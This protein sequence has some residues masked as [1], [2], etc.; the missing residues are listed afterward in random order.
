MKILHVI[1]GISHEGGG[2]S[3]SCQGLVSSLAAIGEDVALLT[4]RHGR[5]PWVPGISRFYNGESFESVLAVERP[6]VVH[7]H[8]IWQPEI[9]NC[10]KICRKLQLP[11]VISPRGMLEPWSLQ[12]K[13]LKKR[14][15]RLLYQDRDLRCA[16]ALHATSDSE[17][18]QFRKLGFCN[19]IIIS[20]NGVNIPKVLPPRSCDKKRRA[21]FVSR[22]HPKKGVA[23]LITAWAHVKPKNWCCEFVYTASGADEI[24]YEKKVREMACGLGI[25]EDFIFTGELD[26]AEKWRAYMRSD[27]FVLPTYSENFGIVIAE[28]LYAGLPVITTKGAPWRDLELERCGWWI[29]LPYNQKANCWKELDEALCQATLGDWRR[30]MGE[31]A[32]MGQRGHE[33]IERKYLWASAG[34]LMRDGYRRV[35]YNERSIN[36]HNL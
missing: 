28:A 4:I 18:N 35:I 8:C 32:M 21:L 11:Y 6:Q 9:H 27:L 12:Q 36:E 22:M 17:A 3:R 14:I 31:M 13:W 15:A 19:P 16:A 7:L 20:P 30:P 23:E 24:A 29:D 5:E 2:P 10:A 1:V 25:D 26:D 33:L 34:R